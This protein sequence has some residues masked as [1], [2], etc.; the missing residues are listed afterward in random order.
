MVHGTGVTPAAGSRAC[1]DAMTAIRSHLPGT[2]THMML[3]PDM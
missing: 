3:H 1:F 2:G